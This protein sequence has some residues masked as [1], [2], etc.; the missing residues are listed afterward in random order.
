[1]PLF[2]GPASTTVAKDVFAANCQ[3][4]D[5]IGQLVYVAAPEVGGVPQ[6][7][8]AD[9]RDLA[10]MPIIGVI[11]SKSSPT[12]CV[13]QRTGRIDFAPYAPLTPG[14]R[15]FVGDAGEP[16]TPAPTPAPGSYVI[17]QPVGVALSDSFIEFQPSMTLLRDNA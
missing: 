11:V 8:A 4:A 3:V 9:C 1:M 16:V 5:D 13:V 12:E 10:K 14:A 7:A 15:Y 6:V 2:F 17:I